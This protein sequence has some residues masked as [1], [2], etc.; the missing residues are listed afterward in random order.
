[1]PNSTI[2]SES[3]NRRTRFIGK[4]GFNFKVKFDKSI[5]DKI[6]SGVLLSFFSPFGKSKIIYWQS[7][8]HKLYIYDDGGT[9]AQE[10]IP[11]V[12]YSISLFFLDSRYIL[13]IKSNYRNHINKAYIYNRSFLQNFVKGPTFHSTSPGQKIEVVYDRP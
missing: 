8:G 13:S 7:C 9:F 4:E 2:Y 12:E 6:N 10:I 5:L 11:H 3:I 1:V